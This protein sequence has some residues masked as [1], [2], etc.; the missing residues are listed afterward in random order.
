MF[1]TSNSSSRPNTRQLMT[2]LSIS[3]ISARLRIRA[4][5]HGAD[6]PVVAEFVQ[7]PKL[8]SHCF[9]CGGETSDLFGSV[10]LGRR[11]ELIGFVEQLRNAR[12]R[13]V[14]VNLPNTTDICK[15]RRKS[16]KFP[17]NP[18][19]ASRSAFAAYCSVRSRSSEV[20]ATASKYP[21]SAR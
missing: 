16:S 11:V 3:N 2:Q 12:T 15:P 21:A 20:K 13:S 7:Q 18:D 8:Q 10:S 4:K 5:D 17:D 14:A 1:M 6:K 9:L 19:S